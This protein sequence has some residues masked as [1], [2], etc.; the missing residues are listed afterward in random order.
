MIITTTGW[1]EGRRIRKYIGIVSGEAILGANLV[2]DFFAGIR[3]IVGGRSGSYE[4]KMAEAREM[5]LHE[6]RDAARE[7]G[8]NAIVGI[9]LDY[10]T[11]GRNGSMLM[12]MA[13]GTA[14]YLE[15]EGV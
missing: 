10:G 15:A 13:Y 4:D 11:V 5:A 2:T 6:L 7:L 1:V 12:V 3:D 14:V 8:A 9:S